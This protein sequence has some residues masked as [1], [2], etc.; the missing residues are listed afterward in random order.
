MVLF[1]SAHIGRAQITLF[2]VATHRVCPFH[3][4]RRKR[5]ASVALG[6]VNKIFWATLELILVKVNVLVKSATIKLIK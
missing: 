2:F 3:F 5:V 6:K 4:R 1:T